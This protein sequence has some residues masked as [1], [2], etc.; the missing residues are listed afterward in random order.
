[1]L[2]AL[3]PP[4]EASDGDAGVFGDPGDR[5]LFGPFI[6]QNVLGRGE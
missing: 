4:V 2:F 3:E 1:L 6:Y 5:E